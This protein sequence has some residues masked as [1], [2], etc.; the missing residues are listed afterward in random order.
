MYPQASEIDKLIAQAQ[1]IVVIQ[2]DNPD[3]DSLGSSLALEHIL[4][5]MG[6]E[7]IM[8]CGVNLP[9]YLSYLPGWDRVVGE[10]PN[11]FDLTIIVDTSSLSLLDNLTKTYGVK[12]LSHKPLVILDHH[13]SEGSIDF[14]SVNL[15]V[16]EAA[17]TAEVIYQ[18]AK[19]LSW[20][21]PKE[22][23][24]TIAAAILSD[25]LG[26]TTSNVSAQTVYTIAELVE[27]GVS[28]SALENARRDFQRKSPELV[29][30]KGELLQRIEY[31]ENNRVAMLTIPWS[32][33]ETYSPQYN[34]PMLAI[35]DM[36]LTI[37]TEVAIALKLYNDGKVTGKIRSNYGRP[38]AAKL[39]EAFGGGGHDYASGFKLTNNPEIGKLKTDIIAKAREL[40]DETVQ[41]AE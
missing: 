3:G 21:I 7:V 36:R 41:H 29:H 5:N 32:E 16:S 34:P 10:L 26:L 18:L 17:A 24:N 28:L 23:K 35:E 37:G 38:I 31:Y 1:K 8:V 30:Y 11:N 2:A 20:E 15:N 19:Q 14:A 13:V 12:A 40:L 27:A 6:K 22:G 33:I 4:G 25:T 9:G 39:A